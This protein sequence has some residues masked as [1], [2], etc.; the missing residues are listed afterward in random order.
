K[1]PKQR[2]K[3]A[4]IYLFLRAVRLLFTWARCWCLLCFG[5]AYLVKV[6]R[7]RIAKASGIPLLFST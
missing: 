6:V 1:G 5:G 2:T 4:K 7:K 3:G